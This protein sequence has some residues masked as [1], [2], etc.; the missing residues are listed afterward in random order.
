MV[1][2]LSAEDCVNQR[3]ARI[4]ILGG[5]PA[6][7]A[8]LALGMAAAPAATAAPATCAPAGFG[9]STDKNGSLGQ[10]FTVGPDGGDLHA[11]S[12]LA[13]STSGAATATVVP[14]DATGQPDLTTP[15]TDTTV[16]VSLS[17]DF[18]ATTAVLAKPVRLGQGTYVAVITPDV[19][20]AWLFCADATSGGAW[21][22]SVSNWGRSDS[23]SFALGLDLLP[24]DLTPPVVSIT[25][26]VSPT[27]A[28][29]I[30]F[31]SDDDAATYTCSI[32]G[33]AFADCTSPLDPV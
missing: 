8:S 13:S 17:K 28:P 20:A 7:L 9:A 12:M 15:V 29:H 18:S 22:R 2:M 21:L 30:E 4:G 25:P 10:E 11:Y 3:L 19:D 14:L 33:G 31:T 6:L 1:P 32:D 23:A 16:S 5:V 24:E 27:T 26:P